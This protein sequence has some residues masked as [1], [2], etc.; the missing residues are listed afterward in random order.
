MSNTISPSSFS[1]TPSMI[2]PIRKVCTCGSCMVSAPAN[3]MTAIPNAMRQIILITLLIFLKVYNRPI[4]KNNKN[5]GYISVGCSS[6]LYAHKTYLELFSSTAGCVLW[7]SCRRELFEGVA[8]VSWREAMTLL[9]VLGFSGRDMVV[10]VKWLVLGT[11][12]V[13]HL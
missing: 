5:I 10:E 4:C 13:L 9:W 12:S 1:D 7:T 11:L 3:K 6:I 8:S 2:L